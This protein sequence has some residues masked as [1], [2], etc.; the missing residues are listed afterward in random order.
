MILINANPDPD[1]LFLSIKKLSY[2]HWLLSWGPS[3]W[4]NHLDFFFLF[5]RKKISMG[6]FTNVMFFFKIKVEFLHLV[7]DPATQINADP[8]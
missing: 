7:P 5:M 6:N 1:I 2:P 4:A 3:S 8:N